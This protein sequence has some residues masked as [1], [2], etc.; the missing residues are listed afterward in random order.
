MGKLFDWWAFRPGGVKDLDAL[1]KRTVVSI[2][3][4]SH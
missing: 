1:E 2:G 4:Y 3:S